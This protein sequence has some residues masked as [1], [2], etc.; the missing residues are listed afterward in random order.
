MKV[1]VAAPWKRKA[2]AIEAGRQ[3]EAAGFEVTSTW[4]THEGDPNDPSGKL[5]PISVV[6]QQ[7]KE[8]IKDVLRAHYVV[9]LNLQKSEGKAVETGIA[10]H[11]GIPFISV[12][13]RSNVFQ[14]LGH[15]VNTVADAIAVIT[16]ATVGRFV[17]VGV[18]TWLDADI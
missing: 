1:Y 13:E 17:A 12:G 11:A 16:S 9:V 4:F 8:D 10:I 7:A 6:R 3:L 2:E 14:T 18:Q 5:S 15:E